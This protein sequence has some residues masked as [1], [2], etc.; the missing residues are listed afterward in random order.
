MASI[1]QIRRD[2]ASNWTE[3]DP[4]LAQG[5]IGY[6]IDTAKIKIGDGEKPW[7]ELPYQQSGDV[8]VF[9]PNVSDAGVISWTNDAGLPNPTPRNIRGPQGEQGETGETGPQGPQGEQGEQGE[10][11]PQGPQGL[12][13]ETGATGPQGPQ[14]IQ[15][16]TGPQ[17]PQGLKGDTGATGPQGE[18][19]PQGP[20]GEQGIQGIQGPK[21][22]TGDTGPQGETGPQG[23]QGATG[24][25]GPQGPQGETGPQ[26]PQ[27]ETGSQGPA[28]TITVGTTTT[29]PAG[30][31]ATVTNVGTSGA[32]VFNFGIPKGADGQGDVTDVK[33]N[34]TSVVTDHV[35]NIDLSG[36]Q[37][38][39]TGGATTITSS[40][41][42]ASR[43]LVSDAS[44]K[45]AVSAVTST[46]LGYL[47]GVTSAIQ[48]Q[49]NGKQAT[50]SDLDTIRNGAS[51]GATAVQPSGVG[52]GT[53]TIQKNGTTI[54]TFSA[55]QS[56]NTTANILADT[57]ATDDISI[58]KNTDN[59]LQT[60]GVIDQ[61]NTTAAIKTWTGTQAEYLALTS[62]DAN[63]VYVVKDDG[64]VVDNSHL[65][66]TG[67]VIPFAGTTAPDGWLICDGS[68]ISRT[69]YGKLFAIIGTTYGSGDGSTTFNIPN[70]NDRVL[71][72]KGTRGIVGT[73]LNESLPNIK[74]AFGYN[75]ITEG[76]L[77][78]SGAISTYAGG[79]NAGA[80]G[81]AYT[82]RS[83]SF[84][85]S[86]HSSI[87][88][89]NAPVQQDAL[90]M[91]YIIKY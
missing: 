34:G 52:N 84:S 8:T 48:S 6:E 65:V 25:Q 71:Q 40:N 72:G 73:R 89:D 70:S 62:K 91:N 22:D 46:E 30:S 20:Q 4:V 54:A 81:T 32:A 44:G 61:N 47:D 17:G 1:I 58:N 37:N 85:A 12:K 29:L 3:T 77:P 39:I 56:G 80:S 41:L 59:E 45:V 74:G 43:A 7:T 49:I 83:F 10:T 33:V 38:T 26:G 50:I 87:Y 27:G 5:E 57:V 24:P 14:G 2:T 78:G 90:C 9:V 82:M 76:S 21:G 86:Y 69:D 68:A 60:I 42:T 88:Q 16:E 15:G 51:K 28:A 75:I 35:A 66:P 11:G 18:T 79:Y 63:T 67:S 36:K 31:Q 64:I 13:G 53:L 19:G 23:P 55:N